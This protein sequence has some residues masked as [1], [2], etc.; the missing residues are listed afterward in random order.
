MFT[1]ED[2]FLLEELKRNPDYQM[3]RCCNE[4]VQ[5]RS[6]STG[7][8]FLITKVDFNCYYPYVMYHSH[9]L[10]DVLHHHYQT[11]SLKEALK[12]F[13]EHERWVNRVEPMI[14]KFKTPR[15]KYE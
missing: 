4:Y 13:D 12:S 15:Y 14:K 2:L 1:R 7:H 8:I 9:N 3:I 6:R 11:K 10:N 5:Y